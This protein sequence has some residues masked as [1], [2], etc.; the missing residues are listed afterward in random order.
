MRHG[1]AK[2]RA[3]G[4]TLVSGTRR[5]RVDLSLRCLPDELLSLMRASRSSVVRAASSLC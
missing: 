5:Q 1:A 3:A 4:E 2:F